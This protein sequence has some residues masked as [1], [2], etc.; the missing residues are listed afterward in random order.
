[1]IMIPAIIAVAGSMVNIFDGST[2]LHT[3]INGKE[4]VNYHGPLGYGVATYGEEG[5]YRSANA[6]QTLPPIFEI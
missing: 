6:S 3:R 4:V 5:L 1:M 2:S